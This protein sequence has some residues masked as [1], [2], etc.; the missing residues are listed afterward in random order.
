MP[1]IQQWRRAELDAGVGHKPRSVGELNYCVTRLALAYIEANGPLSY[2]LIND[3]LGA[4]DGAGK[5]FYRR[6]AAPYE[7]GKIATNGDVYP[8]QESDPPDSEIA[9]AGIATGPSICGAVLSG[10][11][12]DV[13]PFVCHR[14]VG[15]G[16]QH[17]YVRSHSA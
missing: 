2:Q 13:D 5:E 9:P 1:Y 10:F 3:V 12:Y 15:H 17:T 16:G 8:P 4:L 14:D 6:L 7:D 11:G